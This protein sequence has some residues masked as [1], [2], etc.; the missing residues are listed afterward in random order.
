[1]V[2]Q[3]ELA[4][5]ELSLRGGEGGNTCGF[6]L[7]FWIFLSSSRNVEDEVLG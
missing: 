2:I 7:L 5:V 1:M 6:L 4:G 3:A